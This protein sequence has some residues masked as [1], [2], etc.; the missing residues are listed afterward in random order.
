MDP[1][2]WRTCRENDDDG[3]DDD[4]DEPWDY[5]QTSSS[6]Q[7]TPSVGEWQIHRSE[8]AEKHGV[9]RGLPFHKFSSH[10]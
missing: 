3:G 4:D 9:G 7:Y 1:K 5:V 8:T 2:L 6:I 10:C